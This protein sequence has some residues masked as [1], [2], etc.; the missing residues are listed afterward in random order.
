MDSDGPAVQDFYT[1]H[2]ARCYGCGRLNER[3]YR[4]RTRWDGDETLTRFTPAP[5]H[6]AVPGVVYGGLLA[7]LVDCHSTAT[8][9]AALYRVEGRDF[10]DPGPA[11]RCVTGTLAVRFLRP[12]PLG[13][14]LAVRGRVVDVAGRKVTVASRIE[15]D[16]V[17]TV[18]ADAV[19]LEVAEDF[20]S[21]R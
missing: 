15:A 21:T 12:T 5:F 18:E 3:G 17:T 7:S 13:P 11:H 6:T 1:D 14:E 2:L 8:G 4:L 16:G 20:G 19:V 9:A 10:A